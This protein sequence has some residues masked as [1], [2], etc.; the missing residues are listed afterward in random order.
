MRLGIRLPPC[1]PVEEVGAAAREAEAAGFDEVWFPDSQLLWRDAFVVAA[2]AARAT[3]R[4]R[5]GIAVANVV[6]RHPS[7]LASLARS[8]DEVA[9]GRF[10]LGLGVG[11]S[12]L[13]PVGLHPATG[14]VLRERLGM[15]RSLLAGERVDFDGVSSRLR[16]P[17]FVPIHV[18]ASGPRNLRLAGEIGDGVIL[19]SGTA[20]ALLGPAISRVREGAAAAE[21]LH[22]TT[23]V[24]AFCR[25]TADIRRDARE[26]K[27]ICLAIAVGGGKDALATAGVEIDVPRTLPDVYPDLVHAEDWEAAVLACDPYVDDDAVIKFAR[28]FCL[29]G[30]ATEIL[31]RLAVAEGLGADAV[32]LQHVGSY[33]LPHDL[34]A[35]IGR[36]VMPALRARADSRT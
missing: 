15:V 6:T 20:P 2:A 17:R 5:L 16:D 23:T 10:V 28:E 9:A 13:V 11:N 27:P 25:I 29:F 35:G 33:D 19:L 34:I 1:A 8:V 31:E 12:S 18:A 7:V 3:S 32:F 22:I 4:V 26:L 30:T 14:A 24:S 21:K 36:E